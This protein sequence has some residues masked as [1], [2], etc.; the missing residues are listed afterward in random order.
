MFA[1]RMWNTHINI[2][3]HKDHSCKDS[4][5]G[6]LSPTEDAY[7]IGCFN[8]VLRLGELRVTVKMC[9]CCTHFIHYFMHN[10]AIKTKSWNSSF[11]REPTCF[12]SSYLFRRCP[13]YPLIVSLR[14]TW[15][16]LL[17]PLMEII[18]QVKRLRLFVTVGQLMEP[19]SEASVSPTWGQTSWS[20]HLAHRHG[21]SS[22]FKIWSWNVV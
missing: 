10:F 9:L 6:W 19:Q 1:E 17:F 3:T 16:W 5:S 18:C 4:S 14:L 2:R 13:K 22:V 15:S 8:Q 11:L 20:C 12:T 21:G 7:A